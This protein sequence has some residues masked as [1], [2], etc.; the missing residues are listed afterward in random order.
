MGISD[1]YLD[2]VKPALRISDDT[3]DTELLTLIRSAL[4]DLG[5]AGIK[6]KDDSRISQAVILYC[7]A[8]FG[9]DNPEADRFMLAYNTIKSQ[10]AI[11]PKYTGGDGS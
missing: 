5:I 6:K 1:D 3:F 10:L 4:H 7:K 9:W 11:V 2:A 8:H